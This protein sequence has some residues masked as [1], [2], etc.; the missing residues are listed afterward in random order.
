MSTTARTLLVGVALGLLSMNMAMSAEQ[1]LTLVRDGNPAAT[2]VL[3]EPAARAAQ[4]GAYELQHHV[5]LITGAT[6]PIVR[7]PDTVTGTR[8][9]VGES[10]ATHR[11]GVSPGKLSEQEYLIQFLPDTLVLMG[12][13]KADYGEVVY[14]AENL[15]VCKGFPGFFD[16]QGT[17]HAVYDFLRRYCGVRW[18]DSTE[19]GMSYPE[20]STLTVRGSEVQRKPFFRYRH[21]M[22]SSSSNPVFYDRGSTPWPTGTPEY[23]AWTDES[24][25][26][27]RERYQNQRQFEAARV[28]MSRLF[29][30]RMGEGGAPAVCNHSLYGYYDRYLEQT[31]TDRL[32]NAKDDKEREAILARKAQRFEG[33]HPEYFAQGYEG[34]PPQL[35][36]TNPEVVKQLAQDARDYYDEKSTGGEQGI[37]WNPT[38]PNPFPIEAMDGGGFCRCDRC[39]ALYEKS[40]AERKEVYSTG[41]YSDYWFQFVNAVVKELNKTHPDAK[42]ITLAYSGHAAAPSFPVDPNVIIEFCM[43]STYAPY[44]K[45]NYEN[46]LQL[47]RE[48]ANDGTNRDLYLWRYDAMA[49]YFGNNGKYHAFPEFFAHAIGEQ[50]K[51]YHELGVKGMFYCGRPRGVDAYVAFRLMD[52]PTLQVGDL[53]NDYFT[54][55]YGPAGEPMK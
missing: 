4:L 34:Q 25:P 48:W 32:A 19:L 50:M 49:V 9:L 6:L 51:L 35:C 31:W 21:S 42:V 15:A 5:K 54:R 24:Y 44:S 13:D 55:M 2:I 14:D 11:L 1:E 16:E 30:L 52:D 10:R 22:G 28:T 46:D 27:L 26:G 17:M 39:R 41:H 12:V 18:F 37:F 20:T 7:E 8:V 40:A 38:L 53:L 45:A 33:D 43:A 23:Q 29:L 47:L 3:A 36:Y